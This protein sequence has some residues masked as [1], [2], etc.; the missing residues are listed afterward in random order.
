MVERYYTL[1]LVGF[2]G[3]VHGT[4]PTVSFIHEPKCEDTEVRQ[5]ELKEES[6]V[7]DEAKTSGTKDPKD[8]NNG[9]T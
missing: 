2:G 5:H 1:N 4:K 3:Y 8:Q 6:G 7:L 9:E